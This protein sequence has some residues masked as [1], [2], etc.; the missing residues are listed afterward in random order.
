MIN[1][2]EEQT[3]P[4]N[5]YE[6]TKLV[7]I[8]AKGL[9]FHKGKH[10]AVTSEHIC[11]CLTAQGYKINPARL[12]KVVN[13]IRVNNIVSNVVASSNGYWVSED[14]EE[15][16]A[17]ITSLISRARAIMAVGDALNKQVTILN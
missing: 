1:G 2:F 14:R 17:H 6:L 8:V 11:K 15:I 7:P 12:R 10:N 9:K 13:H 3:K 16:K 5:D 4:L